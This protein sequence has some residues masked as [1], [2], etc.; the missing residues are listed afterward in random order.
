MKSCFMYLQT[1]LTYLSLAVHQY[2]YC[3]KLTFP[4]LR[5]YVSELYSGIFLYIP[6]FLIP[7]YQQPNMKES[8]HSFLILHGAVNF[9]GDFL[10]YGRILF[11][12]PHFCR[13]YKL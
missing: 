5:L 1:I 8:C 13:E 12:L 3:Y 10:S 11:L 6:F 9:P 7:H 4:I 2:S